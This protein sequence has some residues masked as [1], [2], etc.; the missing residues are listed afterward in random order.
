M[1]PL[2]VSALLGV[3]VKLVTDFLMSG[4]KDLVKSN[5]ASA[6]FASALD[7]AR[8]PEGAIPT[9]G[10]KPI[11]LDAGLVDRSRL[12][13]ADFGSALPAAGRAQGAEAYQRLAEIAPQ[14]I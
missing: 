5:G 12:L 1:A 7:K 9:A 13:A 8:K 4:A 11:G 3:G 14:A 2:L 10:T 6:S